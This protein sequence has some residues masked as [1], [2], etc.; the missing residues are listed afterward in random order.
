MLLNSFNAFKLQMRESILFIVDDANTLNLLVSVRSTYTFI[1][2]AQL[3]NF[4]LLMQ[5]EDV[6]L[7]YDQPEHWKNFPVPESAAVKYGWKQ[8]RILNAISPGLGK[9]S[10]SLTYS[11]GHLEGEEVLFTNLYFVYWLWLT[12]DQVRNTPEGVN[13]VSIIWLKSK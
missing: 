9:L 1:V 3:C 11:M 4:S 13:L 7:Y 8:S 2:R 10:A 12:Q 5:K 6:K